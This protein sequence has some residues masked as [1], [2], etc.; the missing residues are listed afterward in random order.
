MLWEGGV[1][2]LQRPPLSGGVSGLARW[3]AGPAK[4]LKQESGENPAPLYRV[5]LVGVGLAEA[6]LVANVRSCYG[7][8]IALQFCCFW[9]SPSWGFLSCC[10]AF[11]CCLGVGEAWFGVY[12]DTRNFGCSEGYRYG[13]HGLGGVAGIEVLRFGGVFRRAIAASIS[14]SEVGRVGVWLPFGA[15]WIHSV[16][17]CRAMLEGLALPLG[18]MARTDQ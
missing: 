8:F 5:V 2:I 17:R 12:G 1:G 14:A 18:G 7:M 4:V 16:L 3:S 15:C 9:E 6:L 13:L 10:I 11:F